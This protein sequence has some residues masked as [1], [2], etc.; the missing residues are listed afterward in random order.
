MNVGKGMVLRVPAS[1][2][3]IETADEGEVIV[4]DNEL[5]V[6]RLGL[7]QYRISAIRHKTDPVKCHVSRI[8][9]DVVVWVS[10][11]LDVAM[12]RRARRTQRSQCMLCVRTVAGQSLGDL[13]IHN[14]KDLHSLLCLSLENLIQSI[15]LVE[16]RRPSQELH[17]IRIRDFL[18]A[19]AGP[20]NSGDSHQSSI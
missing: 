15:L 14:D 6:M 13:L 18:E 9:E 17:V 7:C 3:E 19:P 12:A 20:T 1:K 2:A 16:I 10:H 11:E 4:D 5:L 8:L